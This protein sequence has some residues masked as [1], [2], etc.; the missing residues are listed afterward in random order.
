MLFYRAPTLAWLLAANVG[1][2]VS[3]VLVA[4][5][6]HL[7]GADA[8]FQYYLHKLAL[9]SEVEVLLRQPWSVVTHMF[10]HDVRSFWHI[11][12][13][14]LWLYWMGS[15]FISVQPHQ[16]LGW[17]Y[18]LAGLAGGVGFVSYSLAN[19]LGAVY[20][21]GASAAV[22]G[23]ILATV[24]LMPYHQVFLFFIGPIALRWIGLIW[25]FLDFILAI[26]GNEAVAV[27]HLSGSFAGILLGY[28]F[29]RGWGP[30]GWIAAL[31]DF[32]V[33]PKEVTQ[34][35]VDRILDKISAKGLRSL[36]RRER[37]ILR[38]ATEKL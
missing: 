11:L 34:Q 32:W 38:R 12:F 15:F 14:M 13:N 1:F 35:E 28:A 29:R 16:R 31:R 20:A 37:E 33:G 21:M 25:L 23:I 3:L 9:P 22:N 26:G 18:F 36:T 30:E 6:F 8:V 24:V 7:S 27:A 17:V 2:Y 19:G 5:G 10:V 4:L